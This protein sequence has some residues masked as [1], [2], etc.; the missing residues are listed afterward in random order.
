LP[1]LIPTYEA[2]R[3][4]RYHY[5]CRRVSLDW[6][7]SLPEGYTLRRIDRDLLADPGLVLPEDF[8]AG[9]D[10]EACWGAWLTF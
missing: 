2:L 6:R 7:N 8:D 1:E 9:G 10:I 5:L 4:T 3:L